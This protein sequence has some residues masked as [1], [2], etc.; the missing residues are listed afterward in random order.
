MPPPRK[1]SDLDQWHI[2]KPDFIVSMKKPYMLSANGP[3][4]I[5]NI[6]VDPGFT[7]DMYVTAVESKPA[8]ARGAIRWCT[9][10]RP[11][12]LRMSKKES[13][14]SFFQRVCAGKK[15]RRF[16]AELGA[17]DQGGVQDQLQSASESSGRRNFRLRFSLDSKSFPKVV[18]PKYVAFTQHMGDTTEL[19]VPA[20]QVARH[21]GYFRVEARPPGIISAA[22]A[23]SWQGEVHRSDLSR[24]PGGLGSPGPARMETIQLC[25][26]LPVWVAHH[27][28][29]RRRRGA[30][31][32]RGHD[33]PRHVVARQHIC[34]Q[35]ESEPEKLGRLRPT[36][37]RRDQA[38][39]G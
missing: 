20:G 13:D 14:R 31:A 9:I 10:S 33:R 22:H 28:S 3:D 4:N 37:H 24:S 34:E 8:D 21:D 39:P 26:R 30:A 17:F 7:E 25:Q 12:W 6:L 2:G 23:Q 16:S 27:L 29:V 15:W 1:F 38:S 11:T 35:V 19:D 32:A 18:V 36:I 5:V